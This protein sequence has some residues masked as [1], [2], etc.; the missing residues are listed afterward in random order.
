MLLISQIL[1]TLTFTLVL[2]HPKMPKSHENLVLICFSLRER[3]LLS[4][5]SDG[6]TDSTGNDN[7][8]VAKE[9]L[10]GK[11][12]ITYNGGFFVQTK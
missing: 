11:I 10:W 3:G 6:Q 4:F 7:I 12:S 1:T 2:K 8:L 5:L 9:L